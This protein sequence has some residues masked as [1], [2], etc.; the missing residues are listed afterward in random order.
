MDLLSDIVQSVHESVVVNKAGEFAL[1]QTETKIFMG[2]SHS[3]FGSSALV[4][5]AFP[6][7]P[8]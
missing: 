4:A 8:G 2:L 7:H 6:I 5:C 1:V 3:C